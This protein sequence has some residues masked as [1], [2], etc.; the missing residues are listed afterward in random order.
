MAA[1]VDPTE[2]VAEIGLT[3]CYCGTEL[4]ALEHDLSERAGVLSATVDRT[5]ATAHIRYDPTITDAATLASE[6]SAG[7][8]DCTCRD[9]P[10]SRCQP[11]H[12][13]VSAGDRLGGQPSAGAPP[14]LKPEH[15]GAPG[16]PMPGGG[17]ATSHDEHAGHGASMVADM[18]RR[19]VVSALLTIPLE[20]RNVDR[21]WHAVRKNLGLDAIRLHDLRH[22]CATFLLASGASPR[23]VMKPLGH[24]QISL[25]MNTYAHV[26]PEIERTAVDDAARHL[27]G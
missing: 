18:F 1:K 13:A 22:A 9:C 2:A 16:H 11:G 20:P 25:T 10:D 23:T 4:A 14:H 15:D 21:A 27:F 3:T 6:L 8:Y 5:T 17:G 26:L 19:F 12:P 24:S 7:G